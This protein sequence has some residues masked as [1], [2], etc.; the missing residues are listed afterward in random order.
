V[1]IRLDSRRSSL[2]GRARADGGMQRDSFHEAAAN[3]PTTDSLDP[4]RQGNRRQ[5]VIERKAVPCVRSAGPVP[6]AGGRTAIA[7]TRL[8]GRVRRRGLSDTRAG[9]GADQMGWGLRNTGGEFASIDTNVT[10]RVPGLH[11]RVPRRGGRGRGP[12]IHA[13]QRAQ[14]HRPGGPPRSVVVSQVWYKVGSSYEHEGITGVS[15][16][17]ST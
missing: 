13:R 10:S 2:E 6:A 9:G 11:A 15:H 16:A 1:T 4:R 12:G 8:S 5:G 7:R 17:L 3:V 14:A